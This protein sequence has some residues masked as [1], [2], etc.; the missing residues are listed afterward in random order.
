MAMLPILRENEGG[1]V[2]EKTGS[3]GLVQRAANRFGSGDSQ[4]IR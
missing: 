4:G 3:N 2:E 1:R